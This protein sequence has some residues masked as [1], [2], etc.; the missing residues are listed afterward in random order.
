M[1]PA[2]DARNTLEFSDHFIIQP[3]FRSWSATP[4]RYANEGIQCPDGFS[5]SSD[6][7]RAWLTIDQLRMMIATEMDQPK[8]EPKLAPQHAA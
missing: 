7:N 4:P 8:N 3:T 6:N 5:Y 1:I 2:D